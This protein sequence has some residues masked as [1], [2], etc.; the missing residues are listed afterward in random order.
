[1]KD[2]HGLNVGCG[3]HYAPGWWNIDVWNETGADEAVSVL[4]LPYPDESFERVYCG[5]VLEHLELDYVPV[6]LAEIQ[7]VLIPDGVLMVVGPCAAKARRHWPEMLAII[8]PRD[9]PQRPGAAH[10]WT[11]TTTLTT[12]LVIRAGF[13]EIALPALESVPPPWPVVSRIGWQFALEAHK[14]AKLTL[15]A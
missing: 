7:R 9:E 8:E 11:S 15:P 14:R 5:H 3:D 6:A 2:V 12:A 13:E 4:A 1:M 10:Q